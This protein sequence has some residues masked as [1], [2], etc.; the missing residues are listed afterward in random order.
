MKNGGSAD[1]F[2]APLATSEI[3]KNVPKDS[4]GTNT[5]SSYMYYRYGAGDSGCD[6]SRGGYYVLVIM[7]LESSPS[8]P[9]PSSPGWSCPSRDWGLPN[10]VII[11]HT[12]D[13][14][15]GAFTN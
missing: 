1:V 11:G 2:I 8:S 7:D 15:T 9:S 10:G 3:M 6:A 4:N 14:V 5:S 13:Y 12:A